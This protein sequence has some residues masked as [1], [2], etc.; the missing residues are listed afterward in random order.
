[1]KVQAVH[2]NARMAPRKIRPVAQL[3]QGLPVKQ[4][5]EQLSFVPGGAAKILQRV[6]HSA[7]SNATANLDLDE[8]TLIVASVKVDGGTVMKRW[9]PV[10]RGSAHPIL[11]RT[12]H[13]TV[14]VDG[15]AV[16]GKK[17]QERT[18]AGIKTISADEYA[19]TDQAK[20]EEPLEQE[21][22]QKQSAKKDTDQVRSVAQRKG[23]REYEAFQKTKMQ[24][25]GG[26]KK[27]T[28][29]RKSI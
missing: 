27:K 15:Q 16:G 4:A 28:H 7:I 12:S 11:K 25:Q 26:D 5:Q 24:Q 3:V 10:S 13:V 1:M 19:A 21:L 2:R 6:L 20:D 9:Q 17:D 8:Q 29:R 18:S 14:V 22:S 23:T